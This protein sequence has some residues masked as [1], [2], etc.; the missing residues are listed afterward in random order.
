MITKNDILKM[1]RHVSKRSRGA[2]QRDA[3]EPLREWMRGLLVFVLLMLLAIGYNGYMYRYFSQIDERPVSESSSVARYDEKAID[4]ALE[5]FAERRAAYQKLNLQAAPPVPSLPPATTSEAINEEVAT[6][7]PEI[8]E[9]EVPA[10]VITDTP[11]IS[12]PI[13]TT[14]PVTPLDGGAPLSND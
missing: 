10:A 1:V 13:S 5:H 4:R 12:S 11:D 8:T 9:E 3:I 14:T 6:S 7:T 2:K